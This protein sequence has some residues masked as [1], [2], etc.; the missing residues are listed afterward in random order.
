MPM[1]FASPLRLTDEERQ[2][3]VSLL[4]RHRRISAWR[5]TGTVTARLSASGVPGI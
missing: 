2:F 3:Y 4:Q 5:L 1:P